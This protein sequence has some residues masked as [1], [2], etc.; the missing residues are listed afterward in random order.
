MLKR[1][2]FYVLAAALLTGVWESSEAKT[3]PGP[4]KRIAVSAFQDK[5]GEID[6]YGQNVGSGM[7]DMLTTA[8][9]KTGKFIVLERNGLD[10]VKSE[11]ELAKEGSVQSATAARIGQLIGAGYL[12]TGS[13]SEF[14]IKEAKYGAGNLERLLPIGGGAALKMETARVAL[15]LRFVDT[16]SGQVI[17]TEKAVGTKTSRKIA[18]DITQLP[19]VEFGKEGFD[20]T[21]I[22]QATREAVEKAVAL[23]E[24]HLENAPWYGRVVKREAEKIYINT[25]EEDGRKT[26]E[27]FDVI[28]LAE[29]MTD[30]DTGES[31]GSEKTS[32]GEIRIVAV[33]DKRLS[34]A[35]AL[36]SADLRPGDTIVSRVP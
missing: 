7:A 35:E 22:G 33:L 28:R 31:L 11:Q 8:L 32:V 34:R 1:I 30:P 18:A 6:R 36:G 20:S 19:S 25:G 23:V 14:G 12:V 16:T 2:G 5:S 10:A 9:Q 26:G 3:L 4:K 29:P 15:D 13:V 27:I 24:K 17:S 21:V